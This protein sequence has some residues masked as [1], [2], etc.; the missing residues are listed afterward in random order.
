MFCKIHLSGE[1]SPIPDL[2]STKR[3]IAHALRLLGWEYEFIEPHENGWTV[4]E[5]EV[6]EP[7][8]F[9]IL[10]DSAPY[11]LCNAPCV[12]LSRA[13]PWQQSDP[14]PNCIGRLTHEMIASDSSVLLA[15]LSRNAPMR[16]Y[17]DHKAA[18]TYLMFSEYVPSNL[19][20]LG[21]HGFAANTWNKLSKKDIHLKVLP[22]ESEGK[23]FVNDML[24]DGLGALQHPDDI[25]VILNRDICLVPEFS[26]ILRAYMDSLH[27]DACFARRVDIGAVTPLYFKDLL[28]RK[29][30]EGIDLFAFRPSF[31]GAE[32]LAKS[33]LLMGA[34]G[35][36]PAW[37]SVIKHPLPFNVCYHFPHVGEWQTG[38]G[39]QNNAYNRSVIEK[40][41]GM[42][43]VQ[44]GEVLNMSGF[45]ATI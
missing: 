28:N 21:R 9:Y 26:G 25:L 17:H 4:L 10:N 31:A 15:I 2:I 33:D 12:L 43:P 42:K 6:N 27:L 18:N 19:D 24:R 35:W 11:H 14:K 39:N 40:E 37:A 45:P 38:H 1:S 16:Q 29:P 34:E 36:D 8:T 7:D 22:Y 5:Q 20:A 32:R 30:Y 3:N 41:F 23:P 13:T 44:L